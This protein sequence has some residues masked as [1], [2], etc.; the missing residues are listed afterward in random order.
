[1]YMPQTPGPAPGLTH[2]GNH[3]PDTT[4]PP[5]SPHSGVEPAPP[6]MP[7][8]IPHLTLPAVRGQKHTGQHRATP[9]NT[10]PT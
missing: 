4:G 2:H 7:E 6:E 8:Q 5:P 9:G 10:G 3:P 1:M